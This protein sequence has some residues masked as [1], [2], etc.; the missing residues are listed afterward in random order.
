MVY[1]E[2]GAGMDDVGEFAFDQVEGEGWLGVDAE[3]GDLGGGRE[4]LFNERGLE[5]VG[6]IVEDEDI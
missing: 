2:G 3:G 6:G 4:P 5:S 1:G